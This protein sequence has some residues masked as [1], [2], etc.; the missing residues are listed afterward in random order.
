MRT[1]D[2]HDK[3]ARVAL[4]FFPELD[5]AFSLNIM[6]A[7]V[8]LPAQFRSDLDP[9]VKKVVEV[10]NRRYRDGSKK[11][12]SRSTRVPSPPP[13]PLP[14]PLP[15]PSTTGAPSD[16]IPFTVAMVY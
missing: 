10:A 5:D 8:I 6:K 12:R 15:S 4:D 14:T 11:R 13:P 7:S 3:L 1:M 2:E 16:L 9:I